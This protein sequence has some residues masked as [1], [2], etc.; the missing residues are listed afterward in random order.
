MHRKQTGF[1]YSNRLNDFGSFKWIHDDG[2]GDG[3]SE[4][5]SE[6]GCGGVPLCIIEN[7]EVI[8]TVNLFFVVSCRR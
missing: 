1:G 8:V 2:G 6:D 4:Y 7:S 3:D 5:D